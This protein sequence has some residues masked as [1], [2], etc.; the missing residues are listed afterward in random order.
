VHVVRNARAVVEQLRQAPEAGRVG[1]SVR[2]AHDGGRVRGDRVPQ[3]HP[4]PPVSVH[5]RAEPFVGR[6]DPVVGLRGGA[7][8]PLADVATL[9]Q[10]VRLLGQAEA[11]TGRYEV[12]GDE[13]RPEPQHSAALGQQAGDLVAPVAHRFIP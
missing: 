3:R 11:V 12:A 13:R 2:L 10:V 7:E 4:A 1:G 9:A 6:A 5:D 8:P